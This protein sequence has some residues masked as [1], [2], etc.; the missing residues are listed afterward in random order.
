MNRKLR[1]L[2][3]LAM[4]ALI[5]CSDDPEEQESGS[6]QPTA[7]QKAVKFSECMREHGVSAFP[8]PDAS[9]EL[10]IDAVA[11]EGGLD[12]GTAEFESAL[13]ACKDLQPAG[14]TG[15]KRTAAE[16]E[17]ALKFA[18]CMRDNGIE[19]FPDP[20]KDGPLI[21]TNRIPSAKG[22][23]AR[24]IPGFTA[25]QERCGA[26]YGDELGLPGR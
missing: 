14:F 25:A 9:G 26:L 7:Q 2:A 21:D 19:D 24:S 5:G 12:P 17:P 13:L 23:G 4:V 15:R 6:R 22:R 16:Q 1:P 10:T 20:V 8:D 18:Q 3:A 11:N